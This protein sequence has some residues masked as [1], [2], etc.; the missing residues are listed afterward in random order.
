V[1]T[2][3]S[4][5]GHSFGGGPR[6]ASAHGINCRRREVRINLRRIIEIL[7]CDGEGGGNFLQAELVDCSVHGLA[8]RTPMVMRVGSE[9]LLKVQLD[10]TQIVL[11][12]VRNCRAAEAGV[13][14]YRVGAE[15]AGYVAA[16]ANVRRESIVDAL[17]RLDEPT[18]EAE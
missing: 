9:F 3:T 12:T 16:S 1:D 18:L 15:F 10:E 11:Y 5:Q 13:R 2:L 6:G 14:G 4:E 8:L 17:K 7:P